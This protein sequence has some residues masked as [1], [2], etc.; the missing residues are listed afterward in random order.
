[1]KVWLFSLLLLSA[2]M[3]FANDATLAL[4]QQMVAQYRANHETKIPEELFS[5]FFAQV[6]DEVVAEIVSEASLRHL[7]KD[8]Y[9]ESGESMKVFA[10]KVEAQLKRLEQMSVAEL[11]LVANQNRIRADIQQSIRFIPDNFFADSD[12]V[13]AAMAKLVRKLKKSI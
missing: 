13:Q 9:V 2:P 6:H 8:A 12:R 1:M 10:D 11:F 3:A 4:S 5:N 7:D